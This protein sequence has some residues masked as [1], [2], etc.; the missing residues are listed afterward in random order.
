MSITEEIPFSQLLQHSRETVANLEGSQSRRVRLVRR[1]GEDLFLESA[2]RAEAEAEA[3]LVTTRILSALAQT[4][5]GVLLDAFPAA[6]PWLR[7]LPPADA[8]AFVEE[9]TETA[10]ACAELGSLAALSPVI[11][12]W[13]A[14]AEIHSDPELLRSLTK[15]LDGADHVATLET[16]S[17]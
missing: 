9:F 8:H 4:A 6:F 2:R 17:T 14:T 5:E 16:H 10:R 7:F 12:A 15:P 11:E 1:D 3:I 13:R